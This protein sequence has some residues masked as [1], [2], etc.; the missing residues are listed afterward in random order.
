MAHFFDFNNSNQNF[1]FKVFQYYF[2]N[3]AEIIHENFTA[4]MFTE[5]YLNAYIAAITKIPSELNHDIDIPIISDFIKIIRYPK[6]KWRIYPLIFFAA[7]PD[8]STINTQDGIK[9]ESIILSNAKQDFQEIYRHLL[10]SFDEYHVLL[11]KLSIVTIGNASIVMNNF[12]TG[13]GGSPNSPS[14]SNKSV[15]K[16]K[17]IIHNI[18]KNLFQKRATPYE[19]FVKELKQE[20]DIP[21][22]PIGHDVHLGSIYPGASK[23]E[24][25][26]KFCKDM[27][28]ILV[29]FIVKTLHI[30]DEHGYICYSSQSEQSMQASQSSPTS[31]ANMQSMSRKENINGMQSMSRKENINGI[32]ASQRLPMQTTSDANMQSRSRKENINGI[33]ASQNSPM[34]VDK[35][36]KRKQSSQS[37]PTSYANMQSMPNNKRIRA[38]PSDPYILGT[39]NE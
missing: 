5:N 16:S 39:I 18:R 15:G 17:S 1:M 20:T 14:K 7:L 12:Q 19:E 34:I 21:E 33:R 3:D 13:R 37:S 2:S 10:E 26:K 31:D 22:I 11:T 9:C 8:R 30:F 36:S 32:R 38:L 6:N 23:E 25:Y 4:N 28:E 24:A 35:V 27:F 29:V